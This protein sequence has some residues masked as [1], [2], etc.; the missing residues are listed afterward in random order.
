MTNSTNN[1]TNFQAGSMYFCRSACDH[2][3]IWYYTVIRRTAKSVWLKESGKHA[4][5]KVTRRT[6]KMDHSDR[7]EYVLPEG[8]YS[9]CPF[10]S[11]DKRVI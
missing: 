2:N 1:T 11:A 10:L 4:P 5:D 3:C 9:M 6:V 8:Y 7:T